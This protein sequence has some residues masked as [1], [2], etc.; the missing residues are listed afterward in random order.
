MKRKVAD[1]VEQY[2]KSGYNCAESAL[3]AANDA[4]KLDL[5]DTGFDLMIGFGRGL[6]VESICGAVAGSVA[7]ISRYYS[8]YS[9]RDNPL[10]NETVWNFIK[11]VEARYGSADCSVLRAKLWNES[12]H[13]YLTVRYVVDILDEI[14]AT[15]DL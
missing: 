11:T 15:I 8:V 9:D 14:M 12:D 4:W 1:Y 7:A 10:L 13:C 5:S 3:R 2:Y 6:T